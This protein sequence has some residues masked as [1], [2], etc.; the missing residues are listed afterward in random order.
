[1]TAKISSAE[2]LI[3]QRLRALYRAL[4]A[5]SEGEVDAIHQ[6]RVAT[7]RLREALPL[8]S[9]RS[10]RK[11]ERKVP[12][13]VSP[14]LR[15]LTHYMILMVMPSEQ[16]CAGARPRPSA[17]SEPTSGS[18]EDMQCQPAVLTIR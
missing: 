11:L 15:G 14:E 18:V 5:A 10:V 2:V 9:P 8:L 13:Q 12:G 6:A 4:P 7:R 3:R 17:T 16:A 1:M